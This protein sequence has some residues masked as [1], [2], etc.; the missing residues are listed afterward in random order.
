[1]DVFDE[2]SISHLPV[3]DRLNK[4]SECIGNKMGGCQPDEHLQV[5]AALLKQRGDTATRISTFDELF[6]WTLHSAVTGLRGTSSL[7]KLNRWYSP[8]QHTTV[9]SWG[10]P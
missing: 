10:N 6:L 1:M 7:K 3:F 5:L 4:E 9:G 8:A 2:V